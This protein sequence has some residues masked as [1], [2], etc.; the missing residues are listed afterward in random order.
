M[1]KTPSLPLFFPLTAKTNPLPVFFPLVTKQHP[2]IL[3]SQN[4]TSPT[5][6]ISSPDKFNPLPQSQSNY[7]TN[8][9]EMWR[10]LLHEMIT[11]H[12]KSNHLGYLYVIYYT[13]VTTEQIFKIR[14]SA[15]SHCLAESRNYWG[16]GGPPPLCP[17][18]YPPLI[19][20]H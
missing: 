16:G 19:R 3:C 17:P 2:R 13:F 5:P 20:N 6:I 10:V 18:S 12:A 14:N 4:K 11:S 7:L 1:S 8:T 15:E 9:T